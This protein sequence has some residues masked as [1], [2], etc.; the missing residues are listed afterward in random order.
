MASASYTLSGSVAVVTGAA[1]GIRRDA[2]LLDAAQRV[3]PTGYYA[4]L[5]K[6]MGQ[7]PAP[8]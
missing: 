6:R 1:A 5:R 3:A 2:R 7:H 8:P 4:L